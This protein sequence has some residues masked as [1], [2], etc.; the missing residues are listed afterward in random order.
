MADP[1][2]EEDILEYPE[3]WDDMVKKYQEREEQ[4]IKRALEKRNVATVEE[5]REVSR[6]AISTRTS[7]AQREHEPLKSHKILVE[8][9][10]PEI[11]TLRQKLNEEIK[12]VA[13][14][15]FEQATEL[16]IPKEALKG[17]IR[18]GAPDLME[19]I[20]TKHS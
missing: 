19:E 1:Q 15:V 3:N 9:K 2:R 13:K 20:E 10:S 14:S 18:V 16:N 11:Q 8:P 7:R 6:K 4:Q 17:R 5:L 12:A